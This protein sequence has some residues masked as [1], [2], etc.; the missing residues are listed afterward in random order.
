M[1]AHMSDAMIYMNFY[2][3]FKTLIKQA[4]LGVGYVSY[5][6]CAHLPQGSDLNG[7]QVDL[8]SIECMLPHYLTA[9]GLEYVIDWEWEQVPLRP[10]QEI[11]APAA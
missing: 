2:Y 10:G 5:T 1:Y 11:P 7:C 9:M 8:C 6:S 3:H 4:Q